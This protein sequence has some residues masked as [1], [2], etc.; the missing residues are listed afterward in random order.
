MSRVRV[1]ARW[2]KTRAVERSRARRATRMRWA[3]RRA[4]TRQ[5]IDPITLRPDDPLWAA[6][7]RRPRG[8]LVRDVADEMRAELLAAGVPE[9]KT[10]LATDARLVELLDRVATRLARDALG[11][12]AVRAGLARGAV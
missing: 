6:C 11:L 10:M 4:L 8:A 7:W 3:W 12:E 9:S 1:R 2:H 5:G